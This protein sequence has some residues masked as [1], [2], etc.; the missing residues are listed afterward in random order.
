MRISKNNEGRKEKE[1]RDKGDDAFF[2]AK[3]KHP[4]PA[5]T[6]KNFFSQPP[7]SKRLLL[8][9]TPSKGD[10]KLYY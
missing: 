9:R 1:L 6:L 10:L 7:E 8:S 3:D 5:N 4:F 2:C